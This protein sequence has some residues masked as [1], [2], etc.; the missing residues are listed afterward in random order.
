MAAILLGLLAFA[1]H[2]DHRP[3][4]LA[5]HAMPDTARGLLAIV[6][7][8]GTG[9]LG[10]VRLLL[11]ERLRA[12]ELLWVMPAG[13]CAVGLAMT[14]LGFAGV[15]Y[16]LSLV[17][18]LVAAVGLDAVAVRRRGWPALPAGHLAWPALLAFVVF[19]VA[20]VPM[21]FEQHYAAITG[22][23]SDAHVA[24]GTGNF[25]KHASPIDVVPGL[26]ID[27]MP[28]LWGSKFPI[29]YALAA[30][31]S[32][33]GLDTWQILPILAAA[34]LAMAATGMFLVVR[35]VF[36]A[37]PGVAA[38]AMALAGLNRMALHTGLNPYFNQTWGY[39]AMPFTLVLGW[40]AVQPG[41]AGPA[42][43]AML[44]LL[45]MFAIVL[46]F[47]YPLAAPIPA[48][49]IA[50]FLWRERR[51]RIRSGERVLRIRDLYHGRR[52][53]A[54]M[55]PV[56]L[57]LVIPVG[58]VL[59][60][61]AGAAS[62]LAPGHSLAAWGGDLQAF[63]PFNYFL[64][65]PDS[66]LGNLLVLALLYFAVRD[67][68]QQPRSLAWGLGGLLAVGLL[69]A[70]YLRHRAYGFYFHFKLLAF[71]GPLLVAVAA[72]G[73][74][75]LRRYG[76]V[77]LAV[78]A[79]ATVVSAYDEI[80]A[81]GFQLS[82]AEIQLRGWA[83]ALPGHASIRLDMYPPTQLWAAYMLAARP[84]CSQQPLT[85]TDYPHVPASRK[86]DYI[87]ASVDRL[88]PADAAGAPLRTNQQFSL[89]RE[90]PSVPGVDRCSER[91]QS[92]LFEG[93]DH[94]R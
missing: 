2:F 61:A 37:T 32:I 62:V 73:A 40:W 60:K 67:L 74:G 6:A 50:V 13:A 92:R 54:W 78:F 94:T 33:S 66:R 81:T 36:G 65:L 53:L 76:P 52:S 44:L 28:P 48:V 25:L 27:R 4:R 8:F 29:Y 88:S 16:T 34:L 26:P 31:S 89:Y 43:R 45:A 82:T 22:T 11:P 57:L 85:G 46:V 87:V 1:M 20:L 24:A 83:A 10:L 86:A 49:P 59:G 80:G 79:L 68:R 15:Q 5:V 70:A 91:R 38:A 71:C 72:V 21:V 41:I 23:G 39:F 64:S 55:V 7:L 69:V 30:A 12:H 90:E 14:L 42:R 84:L 75:R 35:D 93:A 19:A 77:W 18:V 47:A 51:R 56:S 9:G 58:A 3:R 63:I 17:L